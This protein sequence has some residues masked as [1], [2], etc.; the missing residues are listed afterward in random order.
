MTENTRGAASVD[1]QTL[2]PAHK[3]ATKAGKSTG[4]RKPGR[5]AAPAAAE[6]SAGLLHEVPIRD[7]DATTTVAARRVAAGAPRGG[8][9]K[10]LRGFKFPALPIAPSFPALPVGKFRSAHVL[11][12]AVTHRTET[13]E[14][15]DDHLIVQSR[16]D[17]LEVAVGFVMLATVGVLAAIRLAVGA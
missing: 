14:A 11:Y 4:R 16:F 5:T 6:A 12:R 2:E 7:T 13:F 17:D 15:S 8:F 3:R 9:H 1:V 10:S